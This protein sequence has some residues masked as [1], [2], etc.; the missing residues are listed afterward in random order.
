[1]E[2]RGTEAGAGGMRGRIAAVWLW[3]HAHLA[4]P[5]AAA[6]VILVC[7][8]PVLK[9]VLV[10]G[11]DHAHHLLSE[12]LI[13]RSVAANDSIWGPQAT[14]YGMPLLRF[15]QPLLYLMNVGLHLDTGL[16]PLLFHN[17]SVAIF[18]AAS[19]LAYCYSLRK[20][21]LPRFAAGFAALLAMASVAG[22][23]NSFEAYHG[24]GI[25]TQAM[26]SFFFPLFVGA[27]VGMLR[28]ENRVTSTSLLFA[29]TF[30][31][32]V[33]M[34]VLAVFACTLYFLVTSISIRRIWKR[35][36][37][38]GV[39][40]TCLVAFWLFPFLAH[41]MEMR[42]IP[43]TE[44]R[45]ES[46]RWWFVGASD[47]EMVELAVSGRLLDDARAVAG[48]K[49]SPLDQLTDK[50]NISKTRTV[51]APVVTYLAA[52]GAFIALFLLRRSGI[53]FLFAGLLFSLLLYAGQDDHP[54]LGLFPFIDH[55]QSFRCTY[56]IEFF[57]FA[58]IGL[59][60][61][62]PLTVLL[63][64]A[65]TG[66]RGIFGAAIAVAVV[67]AAAPTAWGLHQI[68]R[69]GRS[70]VGSTD[71][72]GLNRVL[73]AAKSIPNRGYP[74]RIQTL[75][76]PG[77]TLD[78]L[79]INGFS[80]G[81]TH[82]GGVG[83]STM[84]K[85]HR[86]LGAHRSDLGLSSLAGLRY[87][88]GGK[89]EALPLLKPGDTASW[90]RLA[91]RPDRRT[92]VPNGSVYLLD[93]GREEFLH[94]MTN[95]IV[96][97][98]CRHSQWIRIVDSWLTRYGTSLG[99]SKTPIPVRLRGEEWDRLAVVARASTVLVLDGDAAQEDRQRLAAL[100]AR[101]KTVWVPFAVDGLDAK[102]LPPQRSLWTTLAGDMDAQLAGR[103]RDM[104]PDAMGIGSEVVTVE[105]H[106][107]RHR[108]SQRFAFDVDA[109]EP[110]L[111]FLPTSAIP[112]WT[113]TLDGKRTEVLSAGPD[114]VAVALP[115]GAHRLAFSW[116]MPTADRFVTILS[117]VV[118]AVVFG[119]WLLSVFGAFALRRSL[120]RTLRGRSVP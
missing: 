38:M 62:R 77:T 108:S 51:R 29:A 106:D 26:G 101:G 75:N 35:V 17:L 115:R 94:P 71:K 32:H 20:I 24:N 81:T 47:E 46:K 37:A 53:R 1:M 28:G 99:A 59:G 58:L 119:A 104:A 67:V 113:A 49:S 114:L 73:D 6:V 27:F 109:L 21:G 8:L 11:G 97:V 34:A 25:I 76:R 72:A 91:N 120:R 69:L 16:S 118:A 102:P 43:D 57:A 52:W 79:A 41:T 7:H 12:Y 78:W 93:S 103:E 14:D 63:R 110:T 40:V 84:L 105:R 90:N 74:F 42:A 22:F 92:K 13:G 33:I 60:V 44:I 96:L 45:G 3:D 83:P 56:F 50:L 100:A 89:K 61:E 64:A 95:P 5:I 15:Y 88:Q 9:T 112:G 54:W 23:G 70:F 39:M 80:S 68:G 4:F 48:S 87:L 117:P 10:T 65:S 111:A 36:A 2:K 66:R 82:W 107:D 85:F 30:L 86:Y 19:P 116:K 98:R 18:F 31:S 55:V